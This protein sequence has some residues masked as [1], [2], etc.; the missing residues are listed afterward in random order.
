MASGP[1]RSIFSGSTHFVYTRDSAVHTF[2]S[3]LPVLFF[4]LILILSVKPLTTLHVLFSGHMN[5]HP[6]V[7]IHRSKLMHSDAL[8]SVTNPIESGPTGQQSMVSMLT[9]RA[10]PPKNQD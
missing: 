5:P 1:E 6:K 3:I 10:S 4:F 9:N 7:V 8:S 2:A